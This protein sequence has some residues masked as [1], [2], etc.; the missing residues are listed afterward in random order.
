[1]HQ[2]YESTR[3]P[4]EKH[5]AEKALFFKLERA[6]RESKLDEGVFT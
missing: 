5:K 6:K 2:T 4:V 3:N 1:M